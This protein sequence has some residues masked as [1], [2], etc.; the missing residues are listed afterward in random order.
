[1]AE[2]A[3]LTHADKEIEIKG[4]ISIKSKQAPPPAVAKLLPDVKNI[5]AIASGKGGVGKVLFAQTLLSLWRKRDTKLAYWML[6]FLAHQFPKCFQQ[7][8]HHPC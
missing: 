8:V 1:M 7:K 6:I 3:I 4:N 2:Q 5:I